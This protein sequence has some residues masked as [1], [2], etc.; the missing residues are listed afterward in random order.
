VTSHFSDFPLIP[1]IQSSLKKMGYV[2]A[3][4]IQSGAIP[5]LLEGRD[6]LG[7]A[8]TGTGKTA[9][10]GIP[11][12]Q[13]IH[14]SGERPLINQPIAL[15]LAPTREL[16][17]QI[18]ENIADMGRGT[19]VRLMVMYGGVGQRPQVA[20]LARGVHIVIATPG[21]LL[22]LIDQGFCDLQRLRHFVLDE[23]DRMLDM[24][25]MQDIQKIVR[26][27][28]SR[29]QSIFLSATMPPPIETL[30]S[31]L[32]HRHVTVMVAPPATTA[33]RVTQCVMHVDRGNKRKLLDHLLALPEAKRVLV[34]MKTKHGSDRLYKSLMDAGV[35]AEGIHSGRSQNARQRVLNLFRNGS[36]R[37]LIST[38]VAA[39]GIDV[40]NITHVI[41]FDVPHDPDS[42]VHRIGRTA[43][44]GAAGESIT[45]CD[46]E[47]FDLLKE[48]EKRIGQEIPV[49]RDHPFHNPDVDDQE[50][51]AMF[52]RQSN[53]KSRTA[54]RGRSQKQTAAPKSRRNPSPKL[55]ALT[56]LG[57][58]PKSEG[59]QPKSLRRKSASGRSETS[60][61]R[62]ASKSQP[63]KRRRSL[64]GKIKKVK[65][66]DPAQSKYKP[67][68]KKR[69]KSKPSRSKA[70][71][72]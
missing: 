60:E 13:L 37:V 52:R 45:L 9:A 22:D 15:I 41:N 25:F 61:S 16:V 57:I 31:S 47:E 70:S 43:R 11:L 2:D 58:T 68:K 39:R 55:D 36:V 29:R 72:R 10:F 26:M 24:G 4:P 33:E 51:R 65:P 32:L 44:A 17:V 18:A 46:A 20:A 50:L 53:T 54:T 38:D 3:T 34:F 59:N 56:A 48:V 67:A 21:R 40:E 35:N 28:P 8:Q 66:M 64:S 5:P 27:L 71:G 69:W 7:C 23:A 49:D 14:L 30:A 6:L 62:D 63:A 42:Y 12:L 19:R 1:E